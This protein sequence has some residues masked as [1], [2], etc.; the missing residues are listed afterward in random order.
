MV[1]FIFHKIIMSIS[2]LR[3]EYQQATLLEESLA[4]QPLLQFSQWFNDALLAEPE[5]NA[6]H[7]AT[8]TADGRPSSRI[9]L[10]KEFDEKGFSWFTNYHSRKG[11]EL[12]ENPQAALL[13][14]WPKLERQIRIEG[15][16]KALSAE[17]SDAYFSK[18]PFESQIG[19]L[20]SFQS[21]VV[22]N[23]ALLE[24]RFAELLE[25]NPV[26][27]A[28]PAHWGGYVLLPRY[29]EFWQGRA[30]RLH[31]RISFVREESGSWKI[32]RLQP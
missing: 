22:E 19:A 26:P 2:D 21:Q 32:Q 14:Y 29:F 28:R 24:A 31:D 17:I 23:R 7:L 25:A 8:A 16:V 4:P 12:S 18:R 5:P 20:A 27:P 13:F 3:K 15:E 6:M 1:S 9:V 11:Q 30:S 10:L